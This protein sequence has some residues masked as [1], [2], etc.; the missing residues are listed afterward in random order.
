MTNSS[1]Y[2]T[3][4]IIIDNPVL[5]EILQKYKDVGLFGEN[6]PIIGI[7]KYESLDWNFSE[8]KYQGQTRT[9][10]FFYYEEQNEEGLRCLHL[11]SWIRPESLDEVL[12]KIISII[13]AG[14]KYLDDQIRVRLKDELHR[15]RDEIN[16]SFSKVDWKFSGTG[17][18]G[19]WFEQFEFD[20]I[21][22]ESFISKS[23]TYTEIFIDNSVMLEILQKHK[24]MGLFGSHVPFFNIAEYEGTDHLWWYHRK[25][26]LS[27]VP[28]FY[29]FEANRVFDS[30]KH[31]AEFCPKSLDG[32]MKGIISIL[33]AGVEGLDAKILSQL[34]KEFFQREDKIIQG[35][36]KVYWIFGDEFELE[37][38]EYDPLN[39]E[40]H[41]KEEPFEMD[42]EKEFPIIPIQ[43]DPYFEG[44]DDQDEIQ[45]E[46]RY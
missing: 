7:G 20:P 46:N 13:D 16:R 30:S 38:F 4:E 3:S 14:E 15:R 32:V 17:D 5:L 9:P 11:V 27:G 45:D 31:F 6:D 37:K 22:G 24:D 1:S 12:E 36:A 39:G 33:D 42:Y 40:S 35:F 21:K 29:Y 8:E 19:P 34:K 18:S 2:S 23:D 41:G 25:L 43:I 26:D 28:A 44:G 10:A